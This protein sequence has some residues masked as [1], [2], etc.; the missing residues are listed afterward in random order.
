MPNPTVPPS[1]HPDVDLAGP[2]RVDRHRAPK[3]PNIISTTLPALADL[4]F[5][6]LSPID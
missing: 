4:T 3:S 1:R 6:S 2:R 5:C